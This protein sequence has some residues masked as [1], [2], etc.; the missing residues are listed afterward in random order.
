MRAFAIRYIVFRVCRKIKQKETSGKF[1]AKYNMNLFLEQTVRRQHNT[2]TF[3]RRVL[4]ILGAVTVPI[5]IVFIGLITGVYY[6]FVLS[7]FSI[8]LCVYGVWYFWTSLN[9]EFE[10]SIAPGELTVSKII[11]NRKRKD[12]VKIELAKV[13]EISEYDPARHN[14]SPYGRV[15]RCYK[16]I[17]GCHAL[18]FKSANRSDREML[19][20][21]PN[22]ECLDAIKRLSINK[23]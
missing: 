6:C 9:V 21:S 20:F 11:D 16:T 10:Y 2:E 15:Y 18:I 14:N 5:A 23:F 13:K 7:G 17:D 3:L 1:A 4:I 8:L 12:V 22:K 19:L